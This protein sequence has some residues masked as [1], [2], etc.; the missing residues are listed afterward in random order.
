MNKFDDLFVLY[1]DEII[2][3][4]LRKILS[5]YNITSKKISKDFEIDQSLDNYSAVILEVDETEQSEIEIL[6]QIKKLNDSLPVIVITG[7]NDF[8]LAVSAVKFH[9]EELILKPFPPQQIILSVKR[10]INGKKLKDQHDKLIEILSEKNNN[11]E[12]M[13]S[14]IKLRNNLLEQDLE[15]ASNLQDCLY[16]K[17]LPEI[18]NV[19]LVAKFFSVEKISGD[20]IHF[21]NI[22]DK[23]FSVIFADVSGHGITAA[24]FSAMVKA[25]ITSMNFGNLTPK[26]IVKEI[27][28]FLIKSQKKLS[29]NYLTLCY[30]EFNLQTNLITYCNAGLPSPILISN[31]NEVNKLRSNGPFVGLFE[32][33]EFQEYVIQFKKKYKLIF[34]TD[35]VYEQVENYNI[36]KGYNT[37]QSI[38]NNNSKKTVSSI[39]SIIIETLNTKNNKSD[40]ATFLGIE[41]V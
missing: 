31:K 41:Y 38:I 24:L 9:A 33:A 19:E 5:S 17:E 36:R 3:K 2:D 11:L 28:T 14:Q 16:P 23:Q 13:N 21:L 40:D 34:F 15:M 27:N 7:I 32:N 10:S 18:E 26:E 20:F 25:A 22:S 12:E 39:I 30:A 1:H 8:Q 35:G 4:Q 6:P 29:Y 37:V